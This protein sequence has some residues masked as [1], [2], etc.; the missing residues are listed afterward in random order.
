NILL[1]GPDNYG[2]WYRDSIESIRNAGGNVGG[3]GVQYYVRTAG[4]SPSKIM[5]TLQNL[6]VDGIPITLTEFGV[7][8]GNASIP[9]APGIMEDTLRLVYGNAN[10]DGF[11]MWGFWQG[12]IYD[13]AFAS[14][15]Y[16][17]GVLDADPDGSGPLTATPDPT[18]NW[19]LTPT[20]VRWQSLMDEWT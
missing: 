12:A 9:L 18:G 11:M 17:D 2:N 19:T 3:I 1:D 13:Q 20:G 15:M 7:Q 5:Q 16:Y 8:G 14:A 6:S 10:S 4:H